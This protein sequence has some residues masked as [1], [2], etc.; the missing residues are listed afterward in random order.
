MKISNFLLK[1]PVG[2]FTMYNVCIMLWRKM[3]VGW[4]LRVS[5]S[6]AESTL[7]GTSNLLPVTKTHDRTHCNKND[8]SL[9]FPFKW[10]F[11]VFAVKIYRSL[12]SGNDIKSCLFIIEAMF[13]I[14]L[15][16]KKI[17]I[18]LWTCVF[19]TLTS[20]FFYVARSRI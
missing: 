5:Y 19:T 3:L 13:Y 14:L 10:L 12:V 4:R 8:S 15:D 1:S 20:D 18:L 6:S 17:G 2:A 16:L 7:I 11:V 9:Q